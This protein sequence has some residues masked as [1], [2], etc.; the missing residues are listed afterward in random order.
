MFDVGNK[1]VEAIFSS[2]VLISGKEENGIISV[3]MVSLSNSYTGSTSGL[4]GIFNGDT[5]DDLI[6]KNSTE[7]LPLNSSL[8]T[9]HRSFGIT[10]K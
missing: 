9:I 5:S 8:E 10:C 2:G 6:P 1:T 3:L 4:M 7:P